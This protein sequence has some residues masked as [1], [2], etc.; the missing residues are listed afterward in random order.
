[1]WLSL[2]SFC[3]VSTW[4][5]Q[6]SSR[7]TSV[8]RTDESLVT[9]T[10]QSSPLPIPVYSN[11]IPPRRGRRPRI[12]S[13]LRLERTAYLSLNVWDS[14][15]QGS[16]LCPVLP[17]YQTVRRCGVHKNPWYKLGDVTRREVGDDTH[18]PNT[19][20]RVIDLIVQNPC[21]DGRSSRVLRTCRST[22]DEGPRDTP[23]AVFHSLRTYLVQIPIWQRVLASC[24]SNMRVFCPLLHGPTKTFRCL[25]LLWKLPLGNALCA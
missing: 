12:C 13:S 17:R 8:T 16:S 5:D 23:H 6:F 10:N 22:T 2:P 1:M 20:Y 7:L 4:S 18:R 3:L 24:S 11:T 15:S 25:R 21:V 14:Q 19:R 9:P